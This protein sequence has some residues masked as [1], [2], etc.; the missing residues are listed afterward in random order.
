MGSRREG[1]GCLAPSAR[2]RLRHTVVP[3]KRFGSLIRVRPER[4]DEYKAYHVAVWPEVLD[5]MRRCHMQ[6]F[7]IY[8]KDGMLFS[9]YEYTGT[10][11]AADMARL[12]ADPKNQEWWALMMPMQDPIET[13]Q[14]GEWWASMEEV[15]HMD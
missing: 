11:H 4:L 9:Y 8:Y 2:R 6:N 12:A 13:R 14:P 10:D 7:S 5:I 1:L 15:F 3:V